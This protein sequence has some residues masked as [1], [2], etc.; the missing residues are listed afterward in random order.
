MPAHGVTLLATLLLALL[1]AM[2]T[3]PRGSESC[4]SGA[5]GAASTVASLCGVEGLRSSSSAVVDDTFSFLTLVSSLSY[6]NI[7]I[8]KADSR[9]IIVTQP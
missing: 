3:T 9:I 7:L 4:R 2:T 6:H 1:D 5:F 8:A